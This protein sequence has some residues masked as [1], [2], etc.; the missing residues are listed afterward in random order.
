MMKK[1]EFLYYEREKFYAETREVLHKVKSG[2]EEFICWLEE[3]EVEDKEEYSEEEFLKLC[4]MATFVE[5]A[6]YKVMKKPPD[7]VRDE[8]LWMEPAYVDDSCGP[9]DIFEAHQPEYNHNVFFSR[10]M[11]EVV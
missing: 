6:F 1:P 5:V 3:V 8:R 11:F 4:I 7:W 2:D 9:L 10:S